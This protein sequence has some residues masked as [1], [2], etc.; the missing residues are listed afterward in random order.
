MRRQIPSCAARHRGSARQPPPPSNLDL[1]ES[2][3]APA[4]FLLPPTLPHPPPPLLAPISQRVRLWASERGQSLR[5]WREKRGGRW[6]RRER[7]AALNREGENNLHFLP[8]STLVA[9]LF[10]LS[11]Q[12]G[13]QCSFNPSQHSSH[14]SGAEKCVLPARDFLSPER[15]R[16][17]KR[18]HQKSV[19]RSCVPHLLTMSAR[20]LLLCRSSSF[21][22]MAPK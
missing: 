5:R 18:R 4:L 1:A 22:T 14:I 8:P 16:L 20:S 15:G 11:A 13:G 19:R 2:P 9:L 21:H 12:P 10:F 3:A 7:G 17:L 6:A